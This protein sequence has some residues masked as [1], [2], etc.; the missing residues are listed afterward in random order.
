M[1]MLL[2]QAPSSQ[3]LVLSTSQQEV[4]HISSQRKCICTHMLHVLEGEQAALLIPG[5]SCARPQQS[6]LHI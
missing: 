4:L 3:A 6:S 2:E 1:R 5:C